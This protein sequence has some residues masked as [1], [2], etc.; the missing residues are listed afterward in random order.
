MRAALYAR[1]STDQQSEASVEDQ[2]RV[3]ERLAKRHG[4]TVV[5]RY[6]DRA[7]S[8]GTADR[9]GYQELLA[10]ARARALDVILCEDL[11]RL[12]RN[13]AEQGPRLA[14]LQDLG[15]H[16]VT[17]SGLDSRQPGFKVIAGVMGSVNELARDEAAY[18][19]RRGLE[20]LARQQK[21]TGGRAYGYVAARQSNTGRREIDG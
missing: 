17:V 4:L 14:E 20:G 3:C 19:S 10:A 11:S 6:H 5:A 16:I 7:A 8:G 2:I 9:P 18:R 12:W 15:V 13:P 1:Y 21:S